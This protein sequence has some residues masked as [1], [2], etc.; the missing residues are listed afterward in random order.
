MTHS[1]GFLEKAKLLFRLL[2]EFSEVRERE[3]SVTVSYHRK[4]FKNINL[5]V[6]S[7]FRI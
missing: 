6:K 3:D 7:N 4:N 2:R 1:T 5:R